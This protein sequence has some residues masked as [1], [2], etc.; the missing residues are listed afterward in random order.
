MIQHLP[1]TARPAGL[2]LAAMFAASFVVDAGAIETFDILV[3]GKRVPVTK[4]SAKCAAVENP[5]VSNKRLVDCDAAKYLEYRYEG[6]EK[7]IVK[8]T[9]NP[10]DEKISD[11]VRAEL[12]D[13]RETVNGEEIW[14]R[15]ATRIPDDDSFPIEAK[16]RL[17]LSQWHEKIRGETSLRPPLSHRLWD[18]RFVVTLWN[19][20]L[21]EEQGLKGDGEIIFD[22]PRFTRGV[23][24]EFVYRIKWSPGEDGVIDGWARQQCSKL[25]PDCDRET[26]WQRIVRHR[27]ATGYDD[28]LVESYYFKLGLYTVTE[29][30]VPFTAYHKDYDIGRS[31]TEIGATEPIFQ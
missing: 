31:A 25:E 5:N 6:K 22:V 7:L 1:M 3:S 20:Q 27:G 10:N 15:F 19:Q 11:G 18:G 9:I 13:M 2:V 16:H 21:V 26:A 24:H 4:T 23:W 14:Y 30:D 29:F 28:D 17:V 8:F 12:R